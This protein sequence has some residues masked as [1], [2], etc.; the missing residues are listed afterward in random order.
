M[1]PRVAGREKAFA[2]IVIINRLRF[3]IA[4]ETERTTYEQRVPVLGLEILI[5]LLR[6]RLQIAPDQ[7]IR[8]GM[9]QNAA[10]LSSPHDLGAISGF[11]QFRVFCFRPLLV[12]RD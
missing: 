3:A 4:T 2:G 1:L 12:L 10:V 9:H 8:G 6:V 11:L 5:G 7:G